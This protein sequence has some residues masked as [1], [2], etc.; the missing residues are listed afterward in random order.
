MIAIEEIYSMK[1]FLN[2]VVPLMRVIVEE[3]PEL[4][5]GFRGFTGVVQISVNNE[6]EKLGTHFLIED[7]KWKTVLGINE[8]PTIDLEFKDIISFNNFFKGKSKKLPK[9]KGISHIFRLIAVFKVLLKMASLLG[10]TEAPTSKEEKFL[11]VKLYFYLLPA[12]ISQLNKL[13]HPEVSKWAKRS[14]DR[15]YAWSVSNEP[16]LNS[17]IRVKA[18]KTKACRGEYKRAKAFFTMNFDSLDSALGILLQKDDMIE[19]TVSS[20]L[21]MEG[22]PE[23]GAMIG[24]FMMKVGDLAK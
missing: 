13:N 3:R 24:D 16:E 15:V 22:A 23:F 17:Y 8:T 21:M 18:G 11:L 6:G 1:I 10:A 14:P 12:G 19:A 5:K 2:A 7:G 4:A 9:I 20:K